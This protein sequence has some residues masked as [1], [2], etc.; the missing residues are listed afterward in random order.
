MQSNLTIGEKLNKYENCD[1]GL[2]GFCEMEKI[3]QN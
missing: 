3:Y 1:W 2:Y